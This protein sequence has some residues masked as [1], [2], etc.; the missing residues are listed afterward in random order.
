[1]KYGRDDMKAGSTMRVHIMR[2]DASSQDSHVENYIE[3]ECQN[4]EIT[5]KYK[6][7]RTSTGSHPVV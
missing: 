1:M 4:R 2:H 5:G 7:V 6:I 3:N